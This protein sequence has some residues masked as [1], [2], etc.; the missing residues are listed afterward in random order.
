MEKKV[1]K[2]IEIELVDSKN[3]CL[4]DKKKKF[5]LSDAIRYIIMIIALCMFSYASYELTLIYINGQEAKSAGQ[6]V[7]DLFEVDLEEN[8]NDYYNVNGDKIDFNVTN[9]TA[10]VWNYDKI[11]EYNPDAKGYIRQGVGL[12]IDN[13]IV[14][15]ASDNEY[16]LNHLA[17]NSPSGVGS[18][19]IDYRIEE[20]M[21]AKNPILYAHNVKEWANHIMFGSL[22]FYY[23]NPSYGEANPT[24]DI[25]IG[26]HHYVY[27]VYAVFKTDAVGSSVYKWSFESDEEFLEYAKQHKEMTQYG[28]SRAPELTADSYILTLSTCTDEED[29]RMIVQLVRG[30]EIFDVPIDSDEEAE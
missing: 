9:G 11:L 12:Y 16:Y 15:H 3:I 30:E 23:D 2:E 5:T 14:Q 19:F 27:Y 7:S 29:K 10:F 18:I 13:P 17:N 26:D 22:K 20:G 25:Y 28:F 6:E 8:T 24:M 21:N 1:E 4:D